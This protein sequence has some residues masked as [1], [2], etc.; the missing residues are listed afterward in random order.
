MLWIF[1]IP[2]LFP[3]DFSCMRSSGFD[4]Y[5]IP[6]WNCLFPSH[7]GLSGSVMF[8]CTDFWDSLSFLLFLIQMLSLLL[9][10]H[11]LIWS[12]SF[13]VKGN[14]TCSNFPCIYSKTRQCFCLGDP[15]HWPQSLSLTAINRYTKWRR[16]VVNESFPLTIRDNTAVCSLMIKSHYHTLRRVQTSSIRVLEQQSENLR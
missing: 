9:F 5:L 16:L 15:H 13:I 4:M 10:R 2:S 7:F 11:C 6:M 14:G 12:D 3:P 1:T 8:T